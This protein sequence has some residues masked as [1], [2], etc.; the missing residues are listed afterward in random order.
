MFRMNRAWLATWRGRRDR[1]H[2]SLFLS[3]PPFVLCGSRTVVP[4][5]S[6]LRGR[7]ESL[8]SSLN[9]RGLLL[10]LFPYSLASVLFSLLPILILGLGCSLCR[11]HPPAPADGVTCDSFHPPGSPETEDQGINYY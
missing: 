8:S 5:V 4:A 11:G 10:P 6:V 2:N 9:A 3:V 7:C 1:C